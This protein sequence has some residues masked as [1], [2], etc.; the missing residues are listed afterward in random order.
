MSESEFFCDKSKIV[1]FSSLVEVSL[2]AGTK[3][4]E[5]KA[6]EVSFTFRLGANKLSLRSE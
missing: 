5:I 2:G 6:S 3:G 4:M 1:D